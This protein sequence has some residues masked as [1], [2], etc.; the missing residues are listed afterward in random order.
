MNS[1]HKFV[2][3]IEIAKIR[4]KAS[5]IAA[6]EKIPTAP[7]HLGYELKFDSMFDNMLEFWEITVDSKKDFEESEKRREL[8][9]LK[10]LEQG[11]KDLKVK[12][13]L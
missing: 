2:G 3:G 13:N 7:D 1:Q 5:L 12:Y 11:V 4:D 6:I 10:S 8:L 9:L